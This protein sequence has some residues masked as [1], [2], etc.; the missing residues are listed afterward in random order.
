MRGRDSDDVGAD[1]IGDDERHTRVSQPDATDHG[2]RKVVDRDR[3]QAPD[4]DGEDESVQTRARPR[5]IVGG[6]R[7]RPRQQRGGRHE[8]EGGQGQAAR[9][10]P[11]ADP[12]AG[13]RGSDQ[14]A[15]RDREW[16]RHVETGDAEC[17]STDGASDGDDPG[18]RDSGPSRR[19]LGEDL[20]AHHS[21]GRRFPFDL[22]VEEHVGLGLEIDVRAGSGPEGEERPDC[23]R[24]TELWEP[25]R[26]DERDEGPAGGAEDDEVREVAEREQQ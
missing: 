25:G 7:C 15:A 20:P 5:E 26:L 24:G 3:E 18:E 14:E 2:G 1:E 8:G 17:D 19:V 22:R 23:E 9:D 21:R 10:L 4:G 16:H 12:P 11:W 6:G 13:E